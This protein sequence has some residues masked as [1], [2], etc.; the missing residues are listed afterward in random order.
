MAQEHSGTEG[1]GSQGNTLPGSRL[2]S[3]CFTLNNYTEEEWS[4]M[5]NLVQD[6]SIKQYCVG[7]EIGKEGTPHLQGYFQFKNP[8]RW[9]AVKA[10][11]PRAHIE[12]AKGSPQDNLKY[13]SKEGDYITNMDLIVTQ[14]EMKK[15]LLQEIYNGVVWKGWQVDILDMLEGEEP[16]HAR[17][18]FWYWEPDG[19][20]GKTF[21][22][23]YIAMKHETIICEGKKNDVFNQIQKFIEKGVWPKIV[24]CD[25][26]RTSLEYLNYGCLEQCKNGMM[27]SGKYEGGQC[28][29]PIPHVIVF[30]N[31]APCYE[32]LSDDR[33]HVEKIYKYDE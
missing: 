26:P 17:K 5:T 16:P 21:L 8:K 33:W 30:A 7:K 23:K 11:L 22:C 29:F 15:R 20:I 10:M 6:S 32:K 19:N 9:N 14:A 4:E 25:V 3:I 24:V 1:T 13:C 18:I 2:R 27:Y 28:F 31:E 12:K